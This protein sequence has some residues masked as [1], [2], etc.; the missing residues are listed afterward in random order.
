MPLL[1]NY[2]LYKQTVYNTTMTLEEFEKLVAEGIDTVPEQFAKALDNVEITVEIWPTPDDLQSVGVRSPLALF[3]LYRG[4]PQTKRVNYQAILP[5][6][7]SIFAGPIVAAHG[8]NPEAV[9]RQVR[10]TVLHEIGH[11]FGMSDEQIRK[12]GK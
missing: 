1:Y 10:D 2:C 3:G 12:A 4:I 8:E 11:H 7:I 5:D 9:R 6:K